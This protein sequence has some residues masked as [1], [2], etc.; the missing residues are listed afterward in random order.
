MLQIIILAGVLAIICLQLVDKIENPFT[1][2]S[3]TRRIILD[4]CALIDGRIT[5]LVKTGFV[6]SELIV[7]KFIL[8]E[9]QLLADGHDS[10]KR[11][12]ARFGLETVKALQEITTVKIDETDYSNSLPTDDKLIVLSKERLA[13]LCTTD[14]NLNKVASVEGVRVLNVNELSQA[15]RPVMLPGEQLVIKIVQKGSNRNQGVGYLED[16]TMVVVDGGAKYIGKTA[17]VEM[18]HMLQT[19]A[20]KMA[21]A[22]IKASTAKQQSKPSSNQTKS[23]NT[24]ASSQ[25]PS[26]KS[27]PI[28]QPSSTKA[29]PATSSMFKKQIDS[30]PRSRDQIEQ[31]LLR[32][33]NSD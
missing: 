7:P 12:R 3:K 2:K 13:D 17:N 1:K 5:E 15:I 14:F 30:R 18:D 26:T 24:S 8:R 31:S 11:E 19:V 4:S 33:I 25:Q 28:G 29:K 9:L 21:F 23:S 10:H 32:R 27:G 6:T 16:G 20:G 22:K